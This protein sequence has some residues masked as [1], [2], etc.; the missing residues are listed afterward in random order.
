MQCMIGHGISSTASSPEQLQEEAGYGLL[1]LMMQKQT[2][3]Q[4]RPVSKAEQLRAMADKVF[5]P[6]MSCSIFW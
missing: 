2:A 1:Q 3:M 4:R 6:S 5:G